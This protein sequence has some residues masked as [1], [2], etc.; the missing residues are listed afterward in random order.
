MVGGN[1][2]NSG[3]TTIACNIIT[4]LSANHEVI[5]LK[6]TSIRPGEADMHGNHDEK[7]VKGYT[8]Q[9]EINSETAKDT[10]KML[11]A[12][13]KQVYYICVEDNYAEKA[14]QHFLSEFANNGQVIVCESRSLRN[15]I[16]PGLFIM[17]M[18]VPVIGRSKD[19]DFYLDKAQCIFNQALQQDQILEFSK[20]L[21]YSQGQFTFPYFKCK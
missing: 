16:V 15:S 5:G 2:R 17:M 18:R 1:S 10:S 13:A 7:P 20:R 4:K 19:V 3:K 14:I 8:V 12:G 21:A 6:V 9:Q 11:R